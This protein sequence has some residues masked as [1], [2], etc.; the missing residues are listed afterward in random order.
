MI[1]KNKFIKEF[2]V[3]SNPNFTFLA[4]K[5][6][7]KKSYWID[8]EIGR[9]ID[10]EP[11]NWFQYIHDDVLKD[12][13]DGNSYLVYNFSNE[14]YSA[15]HDNLFAEL[16][17]CIDYNIS[18]KQIIY[19]TSNL[20]DEKCIKDYAKKINQPEISVFAFPFFESVA[21]SNFSQLRESRTTKQ[22]AKYIK[23]LSSKHYTGEKLF[24]SLSRASRLERAA[25]TFLLCQSKARHHAF[26]SH[27]RMDSMM[28]NEMIAYLNNGLGNDCTS[29]VRK[30]VRKLP[31]IVD[32]TD[33]DQNWAMPEFEF[34][35]LYNKGL[36][37]LVNETW[38][39]TWND[40]SLFFS[41]KTFKCMLTLQPYIIW[42]QPGAN[43]ALQEFGYKLY[44]DWFDLSF[45]YE[46]DDV[47]RYRMLLHSVSKAVKE[48]K[49][50][51]LEKHQEWR[52]K[53][54]EVLLHNYEVL[55]NE[56]GSQIKLSKF[57][58]KF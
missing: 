18:P 52:F 22:W 38:V 56:T 23:K 50:M 17:M 55:S 28:T 6:H 10:K 57:L 33:F 11:Y 21:L 47:K 8:S 31:M 12:L 1:R 9:P 26:I 35:E 14:G 46:K 40:T 37:H 51:P 3:K 58:K 15:I 2:D 25:G 44:D 43:H 32:R 42:G 27:D 53:N 49:A 7:I 34:L 41:E 45:D 36:F 29:S 39:R 24:F 30:W 54:K 4:I 16:Y 5:E 20:K 19:I 48:I 13:Q